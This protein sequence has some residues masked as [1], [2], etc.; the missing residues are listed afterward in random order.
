MPSLKQLT[1]EQ[2][3]QFQPKVRFNAKTGTR[4]AKQ[5][6]YDSILANI[7]ENDAFALEL[8]PNDPDDKPSNVRHNL[9]SAANRAGYKIVETRLKGNFL[10]VVLEKQTQAVETVV[11]HSPIEKPSRKRPH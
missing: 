3:S 7:A 2:L 6:L 11:V 4:K 9:S 1:P 10:R 8:D 5:A